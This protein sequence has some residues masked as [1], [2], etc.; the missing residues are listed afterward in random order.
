MHQNTGNHLDDII[1]EDGKWKYSWIKLVF[2]PIQRYD[3][4]SGWIGNQFVG[5]LLVDLNGIWNRQWN[6]DRVIILRQLFFSAS[7]GCMGQ[8]IYMTGLNHDSNFGTKL[9]MT[10]WYMISTGRREKL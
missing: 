4:S 3:V 10:S 6:V 7:V 2:F 5:I 9:P 1:N 8:E